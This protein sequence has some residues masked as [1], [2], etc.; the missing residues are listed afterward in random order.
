ML[1]WS[2]GV[3]KESL[4]VFGLGIFLLGIGRAWPD[5]LAWRPLVA[6]I[7]GLAVMLVVKFYVLLCLTRVSS[8]GG[9]PVYGRVIRFCVTWWCMPWHSAVC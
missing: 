2:S 8:R 1:F 5:R 7:V 6:I 9:G 4:L 3:L